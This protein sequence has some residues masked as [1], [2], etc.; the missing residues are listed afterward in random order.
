MNNQINTQKAQEEKIM[1]F[2]TY[3]KKNFVNAS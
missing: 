2:I 1:L 3:F